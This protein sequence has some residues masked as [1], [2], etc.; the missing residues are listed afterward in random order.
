[1]IWKP[2]KFTVSSSNLW[3]RG[4]NWWNGWNSAGVEKTK[5]STTEVLPCIRQEQEGW[6]DFFIGRANTAQIPYQS[7]L[8][9]SAKIGLH[10]CKSELA[11]IAMMTCP[12]PDIPSYLWESLQ[13]QHHL[14]GIDRQQYRN[15]QFKFYG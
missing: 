7:V 14:K 9:G 6:V 11:N 12:S 1:M 5:R 2:L 3:L 15:T 10:Y 8:D 13:E 4:Q